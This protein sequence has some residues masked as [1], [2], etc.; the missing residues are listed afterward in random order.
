MRKLPLLAA[1]IA[2]TLSI[3]HAADDAKI[4]LPAGVSAPAGYEKIADYGSFAL[5]RG[6]PAAM[7][8]GDLNRPT[9]V[10]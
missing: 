3:A 10:P 1:A 2:A 4:V 8:R 6:D 9:L 5:Y 7:P